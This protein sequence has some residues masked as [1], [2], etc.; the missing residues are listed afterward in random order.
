MTHAEETRRGFGSDNHAG[1]HPKVLEAVVA[2]N[3][4]HVPAYGADP[5]TKRA[6]ELIRTEFAE[7]TDVALTFNGTGANVVSL[8][9]VCRPWESV[10]CARTAHINSD[11]CAAPV[12]IA[13]VTLIPVD[14]PDGKL[15]PELVA[16]HLTGFG[17]EHHAQPKVVSVSQATEYGTVYTPGELRA[18]ADQVHAHAMLLHVDGA[19]FANAAVAL[20]VGLSAIGPEAG[21]DVLSFG[22][23]KN[24]AMSAEAVLLFGDARVDHL[25]YVRKQCGQLSSKMRFSS[26]QFV[27]MLEDGVWRDC[28]GHANDLA[29]RLAEGARAAG[30][31]VT[32]DVGANEVFALLERELAT[33][34]AGRFRFYVWDERAGSD[35][36]EV[37][38]VT[39]WDTQPDD[40]D[41]LIEAVSR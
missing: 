26:A 20:G 17:F 4:G 28:A 37:R 15:T 5:W 23:T 34:I 29:Q 36:V 38:W 24:G 32:Q 16:P 27:A 13:G 1:V 40:V 11:E 41:A 21:V 35:R 7:E 22:L 33:R 25:P 10:I 12:R 19:R 39:S 18:L 3:A 8:A 30:V 9:A 31:T 6:I 14:T 2:A